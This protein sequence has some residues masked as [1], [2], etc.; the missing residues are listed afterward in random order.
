MLLVAFALGLALAAWFVRWRAAQAKTVVAIQDGKTIDFSS[1]KPVIKDDATEKK[2]IADAVSEM[3]T[4]AKDV[5]FPP[6]KPPEK[7]AAST[8]PEPAKTP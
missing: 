7:K 5:T 4:A 2:I 3:D 8:P 1:G 6:A